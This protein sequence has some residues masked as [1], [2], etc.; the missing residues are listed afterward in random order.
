MNILNPLRIK[1]THNVSTVIFA[2][3][4]CFAASAKKNPGGSAND[5][6]T[7]IN[8]F[9]ERITL[10]E[11]MNAHENIKPCLKVIWRSC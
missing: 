11:N 7:S 1:T 6:F 3:G 5:I 9:S 2:L 4:V 10:F 8:R